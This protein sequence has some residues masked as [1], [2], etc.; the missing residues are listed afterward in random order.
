[1]AALSKQTGENFPL[2][3]HNGSDPVNPSTELTLISSYIQTL[4]LSFFCVYFWCVMIF[5][6]FFFQAKSVLYKVSLSLPD[7]ALLP[8]NLDAVHV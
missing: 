8:V 1:M 6:S 7:E 2:E 5:V 4:L 3:Y